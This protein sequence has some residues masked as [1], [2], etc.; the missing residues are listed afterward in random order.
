MSLPTGQRVYE[1][2]VSIFRQSVPSALDAFKVWSQEHRVRKFC[3]YM[4]IANPTS[5][6]MQ[7]G[8]PVTNYPSQPFISHQLL[9]SDGFMLGRFVKCGFDED[10]L[11]PS[12]FAVYEVNPIVLN[13]FVPLTSFAE[14]LIECA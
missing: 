11:D 9:K 6:E 8:F 5:S 13:Y 10:V 2:D 3:E 7:C 1:L 12:P 4:A 14:M